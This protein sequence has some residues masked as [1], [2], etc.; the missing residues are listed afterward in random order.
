LRDRD[1]QNPALNLRRRERRPRIEC[2]GIEQCA[3][4]QTGFADDHDRP[5]KRKRQRP[6][7]N[8]ESPGWLQP[9]PVER[10]RRKQGR[11]H[12]GQN[13]RVENIERCRAGYRREHDG[14]DCRG[15]RDKE[16][17]AR[18]SLCAK[19]ADGERERG[20]CANSQSGDRINVQVKWNGTRERH[21]HCALAQTLAYGW[22]H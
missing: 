14:R 6:G 21:D 3:Q 4:A 5:S 12:S 8:R 20:G 16:R 7:R 2:A 18:P 19:Q 13:D 10:Q 11:E 17:R 15:R 1:V 22:D 9:P